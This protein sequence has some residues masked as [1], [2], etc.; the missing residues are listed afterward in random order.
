MQAHALVMPDF[1]TW[2]P[3]AA[4]AIGGLVVGVL[5]RR[6][7]LTWL[8]RLAA[9]SAWRF[10]DVLIAS[11]NGPVV[12]WFV[13]LGLRLAV[14]M[15]PLTDAADHTIGTI[16]LIVGILSVTWALARFTARMLKIVASHRLPNVSLLANLS[17]VI[18]FS[19]GV[20]IIFDTMGL[21]IG[22][23]LGA[24]G[25][26]GLAVGL[27]LQDTLANFFA[28]LRIIAA[29]TIRSGDHVKLETG[30]EGVIEDIS[31]GLTT[32][33]EGAGN[34]IIVPNSR[35][36]TMIVINY[37]LPAAAQ[38]V[39]VDLGVGYD[40]DLD[41][42]EKVVLDVA[43]ETLRSVPEGM[44][45]FIPALRF[46]EFGEYSIK[47]FVVLQA[48]SQGDR[49]AV[50]SD[51]IKRLHRRFE[52]EGILIPLP[53]RVVVTRSGDPKPENPPASPASR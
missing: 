7:V 50:V 21:H 22:A 13:L 14:R 8:A 23:V 12:I 52:K 32:V 11:I 6:T 4:A 47:F 20:L 16:I 31:W 45:D 5:V 1:N 18:V 30:Q 43:R 17:Q 27:A 42:V 19:I 34:M 24:L 10:D 44:P 15:M 38:N 36:G 3:P 37:A 26:G 48:K 51:F 29:H 25:I 28:G 53:H 49:W 33:R 46:K 41:Q 40:A 39:T 9:K 35:L 2:W